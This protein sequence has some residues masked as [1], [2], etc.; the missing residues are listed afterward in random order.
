MSKRLNMPI[1]E[2]KPDTKMETT[3][4]VF[5]D[6]QRLIDELIKENIALRAALDVANEKTITK[7]K[8]RARR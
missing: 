2:L 5:Q 3:W 4:A 6:Y 7:W 8:R 1:G